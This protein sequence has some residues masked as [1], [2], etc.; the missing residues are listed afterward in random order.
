[1]M[2]TRAPDGAKKCAPVAKTE[3]NI[4]PSKDDK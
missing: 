4:T 1:M 2:N 3:P